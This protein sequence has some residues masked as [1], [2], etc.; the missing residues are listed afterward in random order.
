MAVYGP[1]AQVNKAVRLIIVDEPLLFGVLP[2]TS[3]PL[4]GILLLLLIAVFAL[5]LP[6][7]VTGALERLVYVDLKTKTS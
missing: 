3:V 6:Q 4:V 7:R 2:A 1:G 5:N